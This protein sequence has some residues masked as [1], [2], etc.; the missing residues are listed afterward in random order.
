[1][2]IARNLACLSIFL[3]AAC[4]ADPAPDPVEQI[5][6]R[7]PGAAPVAVVAAAA[8]TGDPASALIAKGEAAFA[9]CSAC[10]TVARDAANGAG[11][12]LFGIVGQPAGQ[13]A[14]FAY[15]D[16]LKG[17][18]I[19]WTA[20][21]LDSFIADPAAKIPGTTMVAGAL[22]DA[23]KRQAVIAYLESIAAN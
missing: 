2:T 6:V 16:A 1:M 19:T 8:P 17:S 3:L 9:N 11:P 21:E 4:G 13:V 23:A 5:I 18:G 10:H 12:N 20:A 14:G 22:A 15:S 7:A